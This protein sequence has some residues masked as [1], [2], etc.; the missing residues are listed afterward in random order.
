MTLTW[1]KFTKLAITAEV[2]S[3]TTFDDPKKEASCSQRINQGGPNASRAFYLSTQILQPRAPASSQVT[4]SQ[5]AFTVNCVAAFRILRSPWC[6]R[7]GSWS[8]SYGNKT[9]VQRL[10]YRHINGEEHLA[11]V[12]APVLN[13]WSPWASALTSLVLLWHNNAVLLTSG[14]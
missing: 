4:S 1:V 6:S 14:Q 3:A 13:S 7:S 5:M 9:S 12:H 10:T 8:F 11:G 2:W